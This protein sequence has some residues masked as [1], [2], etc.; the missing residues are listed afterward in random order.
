MD[1]PSAWS[2]ACVCGRMF[3]VPQAYTFH[4]R[5]CQ[6]TKKRLSSALE[7]AKE[8]WQAKKRQKTEAKTLAG[9]SNID[10]VPEPVTNEAHAAQEVRSL[11][12]IHLPARSN[13]L[14]TRVLSTSCP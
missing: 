11:F 13:Q 2:E 8:V 1:L 10:R 9:S 5:S 3:S 6:K 12:L 14:P 7:K 4:K